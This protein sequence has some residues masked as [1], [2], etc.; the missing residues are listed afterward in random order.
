ML[1]NDTS[2]QLIEVNYTKREE[3]LFN[4]DVSHSHSDYELYYLLDGER[5]Y[6]IKDQ[7]YPIKKG[8]L[9]LIPPHVLHKTMNK[10]AINH[11]RLLVAINVAFLEPLMLQMPGYDWFQCFNT[12][13]PVLTINPKNQAYVQLLL[14]KILTAYEEA[15]DDSTYYIKVLLLKLLLQLN[16]YLEEFTKERRIHYTSKQLKLFEIVRY[17]NDHYMENITL[18][19]LSTQ[20]YISPY[21]LS[22]SFKDVIGFSF[23]DYLTQV[24]LLEAKKLLQYS[25]RSITHVSELVGYES[26]THFGRAFKKNN[27]L[28]PSQYRKN[29]SHLNS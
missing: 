28:T 21:Y 4:M 10:S 9:V 11:E 12:G 3:E 22:H 15:K 17:I 8:D 26:S 14:F 24:R 13:Q 16:R 1:H 6:F 27:Q 25:S 18:T 19:S 20:F 7:S 23:S 29:G 2:K 5:Y